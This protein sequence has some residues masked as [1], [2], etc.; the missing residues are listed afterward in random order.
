MTTHREARR[1]VEIATA[2]WPRLTHFGIGV[3]DE[4]YKTPEVMRQ[5]L[6]RNAPV[7]IR[8]TRWRKLP[9]QS[10]S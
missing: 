1:A 9:R 6:K 2:L 4:P 3:Y 10:H 5:S 8:S 7:S